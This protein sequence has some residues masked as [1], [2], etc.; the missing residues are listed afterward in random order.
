LEKTGRTE[1]NFLPDSIENGQTAQLNPDWVEWFMGFPVGWTD[2]ECDNPVQYDI[3]I[4]PDIP[5]VARGM[6]KRVDR[7]KTLGNAVVPQVVYEIFKAIDA[8]ANQKI[9]TNGRD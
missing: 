8:V 5:R 6:K 2:S 1:T 3:S 9:I 4:E 7:L